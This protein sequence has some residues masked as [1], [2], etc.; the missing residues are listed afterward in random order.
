MYISVKTLKL[1][2]LYQGMKNYFMYFAFTTELVLVFAFAFILPL[3]YGI[4]TR[5]NLYPHFGVC[6]MPFAL[7][8]LVW[9][10]ARKYMIRNHPK[11]KREFPNWWERCVNF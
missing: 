9:N 6:G 10:E 1:S 5:D 8:V 11:I 4:G 2:V 7:F 3:N